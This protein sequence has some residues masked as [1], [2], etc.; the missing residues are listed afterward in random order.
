MTLTAQPQTPPFASGSGSYPPA[1]RQRRYLSAEAP[2]QVWAVVNYARL[3]QPDHVI[4]WAFAS[5]RGILVCWS[6]NSVIHYDDMRDALDWAKDGLGHQHV[7]TEVW[8]ID[9]YEATQP[10]G[11]PV[12]APKPGGDPGEPVIA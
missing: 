6:N 7:T 1:R 2:P 12:P 5:P 4:G 8:R 10:D 9:R 3:A 11:E